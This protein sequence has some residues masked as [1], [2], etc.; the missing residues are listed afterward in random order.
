[1]ILVGFLWPFP[2]CLG[3]LVSLAALPVISPLIIKWCK[4]QEGDTYFGIAVF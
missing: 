1:M 2:L 3:S 4:E